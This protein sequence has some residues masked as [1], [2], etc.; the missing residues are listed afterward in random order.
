MGE[1]SQ[2]VINKQIG[3]DYHIFVGIM[4]KK[5]GTETKRAGS[6]TE[7]EFSLAYD[8]YKKNKDIQMH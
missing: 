8:R 3:S 7:E 4:W 1:D 5:F 6:G 2:D